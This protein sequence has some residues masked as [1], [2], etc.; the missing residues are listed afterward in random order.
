ML[1]ISK[2]MKENEFL[3]RLR[4]LKDIPN[5]LKK[6]ISKLIKKKS[7]KTW[8][9]VL[10]L[11]Y[12]SHSTKEPKGLRGY[13]RQAWEKMKK[14][15]GKSNF[16]GAVQ[17]INNPEIRELIAQILRQREEYERQRQIQL[18]EHKKRMKRMN[19]KQ[20]GKK[21]IKRKSKMIKKVP[22]SL[23]KKC[24]KLKVRLT[25]KR[26]K[27][28][29][30]KSEKVLKK[31]CKTA[32][33]KKKKVVK[34]K[35]KFG[36]ARHGGRFVPQMS[37]GFGRPYFGYVTSSRQSRFG[38]RRPEFHYP[39]HILK[40][41]NTAK[42]DKK[43][44]FGRPHKHPLRYSHYNPAKTGKTYRFGKSKKIKD[45][46]FRDFK[47][48][49]LTEVE[50]EYIQTNTVGLKNKKEMQKFVT[51]AAKIGKRDLNTNKILLTEKD[52]KFLLD[53][54]FPPMLLRLMH[55]C[56]L[57]PKTCAGRYLGGILGLGFALGTGVGVYQN[58]DLL[59]LNN[60]LL[61]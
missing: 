35:R 60:T 32:M 27:K 2:T 44:R 29:V 25:V 59:H 30:Y 33:K 36:A 22:E 21:K 46:R 13:V 1:V 43:F 31:Q 8:K 57:N 10:K 39:E 45:S 5:P 7:Y 48:K 6:K 49:P 17:H 42:T 47:K 16:G 54:G 41:Y 55:Y 4:K 23:K 38:S 20:F 12:E 50:M 52:K 26:G 56:H 14:V 51:L 19:R 34:R 18:E 58:W 61:Q 37:N 24:R 28:R 15:D 11:L 40:G 9:E 3:K 53:H